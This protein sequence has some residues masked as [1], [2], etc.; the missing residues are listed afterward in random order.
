[1]SKFSAVSLRLFPQHA[2]TATVR[3]LMVFRG[4]G[5]AGDSAPGPPAEMR[6]G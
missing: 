3:A 2:P 1:M 4:P 5:A 6:V